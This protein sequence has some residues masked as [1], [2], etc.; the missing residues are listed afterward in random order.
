MSENDRCY[1]DEDAEG[2]VYLVSCSAL[3]RRTELLREAATVLDTAGREMASK[4]L[5][6]KTYAL[7]KFTAA[8]IRKELGDA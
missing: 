8:T 3:S 4:C 2:D 6:A 7:M 1:E 5:G